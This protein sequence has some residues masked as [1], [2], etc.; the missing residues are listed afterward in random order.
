[1]KIND[2]YKIETDRDLNYILLERFT[3][4]DGTYDYKPR[5]LLQ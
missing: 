2:L 5:R 3:K 4:K 1:M